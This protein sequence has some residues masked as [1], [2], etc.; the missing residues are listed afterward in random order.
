MI[1]NRWGEL[2]FSSNETGTGW[3]G[4]F[5]GADCPAGTYVWI[6]KYRCMEYKQEVDNTLKGVVTLLR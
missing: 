5:N 1:F 4:T 3:D 2:V 6:L